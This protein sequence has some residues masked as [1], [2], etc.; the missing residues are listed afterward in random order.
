MSKPKAEQCHEPIERRTPGKRYV[1][2]R[3]R[4]GNRTTN[5][6]GYCHQHNYEY[7]QARYREKIGVADQ[8]DHPEKEQ[9]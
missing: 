4:C 9:K 2:A 8:S 7:R 1:N 5:V 3:W 6:T